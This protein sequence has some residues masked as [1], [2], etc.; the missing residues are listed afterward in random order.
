MTGFGITSVLLTWGPLKTTQDHVDDDG[1]G[2]CNELLMRC[3][4]RSLERCHQGGGGS[5]DGLWWVPK[6]HSVG[7]F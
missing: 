4:R 7:G 3:E 2:K 1:T 5:G 6:C